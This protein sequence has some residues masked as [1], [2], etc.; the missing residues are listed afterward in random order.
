MGAFQGSFYSNALGQ[1]TRVG[2]IFPE[3]STDVTLERPGS[4]AVLYLL[5]GLGGNS[6][7]WIR[8]SK[9]EYFAKKFN[10]IVILPEVGRSFY[11]DYPAG[12]KYFTYVAD[13]LPQICETW[14]RL[15]HQ[16]ERTFLAGESM[17]GYGAVKIALRRPE[18]FGA[19]ASLS[20]ALDYSALARRVMSGAWPDMRPGEFSALHGPD[21]LPGAEDDVLELVRRR[22]RDPGRPRMIQL[23]G[24]EDFLYEDNQTFRRT[25]EAAGYGHTYREGPGEHAWPYWDKAIQQ[26]IW[27]FLELEEGS[28]PLF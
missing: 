20:G 2:I 6:E 24:T 8:F 14:L 10:L 19:V 21:G 12:A 11:C 18:R 16:R 23:C 28:F 9:L 17:G 27:F 13:E 15:P 1:N 25:A 5:H 4:P 22:A 7:E 3:E 26:A